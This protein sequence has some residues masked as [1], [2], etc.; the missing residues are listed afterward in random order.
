M[1]IIAIVVLHFLSI[2]LYAQA[3]PGKLTID[4]IMADPKWIGTSLRTCNGAQMVLNCISNGIRKMLQPIQHIS[5]QRITE[6]HKNWRVHEGTIFSTI[7]TLFITNLA[8]RPSIK[9][10]VIFFYWIPKQEKPGR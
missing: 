5:L 10:T 7:V 3:Q 6:P 8:V 4:K 1:K 9:K 2:G